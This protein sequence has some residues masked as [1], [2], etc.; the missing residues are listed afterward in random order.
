MCNVYMH[1]SD[2]FEKLARRENVAL[3]YLTRYDFAHVQ[4]IL[5]ATEY[6][7]STSYPKNRRLD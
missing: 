3:G 4:E 6:G 1:V 5:L 7:V 2:I